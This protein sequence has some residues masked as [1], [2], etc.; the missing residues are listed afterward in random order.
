MNR[1]QLSRV[2]LTP[3][4]VD[5]VVFWTKD[6]LNM[7]P[8]LPELDSLGFKNKYCFLFTLTPYDAVLEPGL[9]KKTGIEDTFIELSGLIGRERVV[10]RYD[11]IVLNASLDTE[12][13]KAQFERLCGRLSGYTDTVIISFVDMYN[14]LKTNLV[15]EITADEMGELSAFIG[16]TAKEHGLHTS[17][18]CERYDL[19]VFGIERTGCINK[20]WLERICGCRLNIKPDKNQRD[21]CGCAESIDIGAYDTCPAGCIYCYANNGLPAAQRRHNRHDPNGG[22][23]AGIVGDSEKITDRKVKSHKT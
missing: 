9:R 22:L 18:C 16:K 11:P 6:A 17:A 15:R 10:W 21:G 1:V 20:A 7:L 8:Y 23:L 13:H 12:Y 2:S 5:C 4:I 3:D 14:K 19:A